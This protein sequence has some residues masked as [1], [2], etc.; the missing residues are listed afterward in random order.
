MCLFFLAPP[1]QVGGR[2]PR[3]ALDR[4]P[5]D[6]PRRWCPAG[7]PVAGADLAVC[8]PAASGM[9]HPTVVNDKFAV[10]SDNSKSF[11]Q[12]LC[13]PSTAVGTT[14]GPVAGAADPWLA[15]NNI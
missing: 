14:P 7:G 6:D 2:G 3:D 15:V 13:S 11:H 9:Q 8:P 5:S 4:H 1:R 12:L 10:V